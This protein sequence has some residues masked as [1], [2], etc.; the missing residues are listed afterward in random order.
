MFKYIVAMIAVSVIGLV[1]A[2][3][4]IGFS[5]GKKSRISQERVIIQEQTAEMFLGPLPSI[6]SNTGDP[7]LDYFNYINTNGGL[8]D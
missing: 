4:V 7:L 6:V 8:D 1:I 3:Y 2:A 5:M